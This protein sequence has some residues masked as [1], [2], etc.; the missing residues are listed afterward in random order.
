MKKVTN[1]GDTSLTGSDF[2]FFVVHNL[3]EGLLYGLPKH[4][5]VVFILKVNYSVNVSILNSFNVLG[6]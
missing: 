6:N 2:W 4:Q 3:Y 5:K 1:T